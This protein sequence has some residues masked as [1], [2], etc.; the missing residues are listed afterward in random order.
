M[1][2]VTGNEFMK[3]DLGIGI[4]HKESNGAVFDHC[5]FD[6]ALKDFQKFEITKIKQSEVPK[7]SESVFKVENVNPGL[8]KLRQ[9][10]NQYN[11][12]LNKLMKPPLPKQDAL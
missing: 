3:R 4:Y 5:Q 6:E 9:Q 7:G 12:K 11:M 8:V 2:V 1:N 10:N